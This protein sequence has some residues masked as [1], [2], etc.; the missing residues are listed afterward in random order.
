MPIYEYQCGACG[1]QHEVI[2]KMSEGPLKKCPACGKLRLTRLISA[3]VFRL[4]GGGWYET[5]FKSDAE[6]KRNLHA[7]EKGDKADK[8]DTADKAET[9]AKD[10]SD[11]KDAKADK[12]EKPDK[13]DSTGAA[14]GKTPAATAAKAEA[15]K[16][17]AKETPKA[18]RPA[19]SRS[20]AKRPKT[21]RKPPARR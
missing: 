13:A 7:E 8:A 1:A 2:Q 4:K 6:S 10:A 16:A 12:S 18:A 3:P 11:P 9:P 19:A 17:A 5:D 15:G 20:A 21:A 14:D